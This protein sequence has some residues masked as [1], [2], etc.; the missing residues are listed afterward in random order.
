MYRNTSMAAALMNAQ[1]MKGASAAIINRV[2]RIVDHKLPNGRHIGI[3]KERDWNAKLS[4]A[5]AKLI[6]M[7]DCTNPM[8]YDFVKGHGIVPAM[9]YDAMVR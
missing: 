5:T 2:Q 6:G 4:F 7:P 8:A 1:P 3:V 9:A